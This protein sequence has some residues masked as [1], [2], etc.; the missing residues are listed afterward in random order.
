MNFINTSSTFSSVTLSWSAPLLF[1]G[2]NVTAYDIDIIQ[3]AGTDCP[4]QQC[5]L[6]PSDYVTTIDNLIHNTLYTFTITASSCGGVGTSATLNTSVIGRG[7]LLSVPCMHAYNG[8]IK[9]MH[10]NLLCSSKCSS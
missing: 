8:R 1:G 9:L 3:P 2:V 5:S 4:Q 10:I 6:G 7:M